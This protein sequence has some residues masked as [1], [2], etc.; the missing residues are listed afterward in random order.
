MLFW[1]LGAGWLGTPLLHLAQSGFEQP[2]VP[3]DMRFASRTIFVL[4]GGGTRYDDND[5][6]VPRRDAFTRV[7]ATADLYRECRRAGGV[8]SVVVSG[9]NPEH[10]EQAEADN[11]A[12]FL[13]ARG[14]NAGD[15]LRENESVNTYENARN[16]AR[17]L[18]PVHDESF[19]LV[20]SAYHMRRS[21]AA[22]SAFGMNAQPFVSNVR[23]PRVSFFPRPRGFIDSETALH[24][25]V[26]LARFYVYR[27]VG[28]Y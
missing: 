11:Y 23:H 7:I 4:L 24:E 18:G 27:T 6:L 16:V 15:V 9:G 5:R 12:P 13:V 8:C 28:L 25:M 26:G 20:T 22:F 10:H 19:V 2:S 3:Q 1:A 14:V 21:L 17:L